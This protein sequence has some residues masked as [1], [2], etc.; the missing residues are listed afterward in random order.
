MRY[1]KI[2]SKH[3]KC[4]SRILYINIYLIT[5]TKI[6]NDIVFYVHVHMLLLCRL[7]SVLLC[8]FYVSIIM[9]S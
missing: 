4:D 1:D 3:R 7:I 2:I 9:Y 6:L 5:Q 8:V